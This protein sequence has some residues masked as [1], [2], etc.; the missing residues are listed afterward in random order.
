MEMLEAPMNY[1][2]TREYC[3][4]MRGSGSRQI[5]RVSPQFPGARKSRRKAVVLVEVRCQ[6]GRE[7]A[8]FVLQFEADIP[9]P[10]KRVTQPADNFASFL[11]QMATAAG[12]ALAADVARG[13]EGKIIKRG[14]V[15]VRR[16][17]RIE[18]STRKAEG[19][20]SISRH[21]YVLSG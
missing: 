18:T 4:M 3:G 17:L 13:R 19:V 6:E 9:A 10:S 21:G 7:A 15:W 16:G 1:L 20:R 12:R 14:S 8:L 5:R 2:L 11:D